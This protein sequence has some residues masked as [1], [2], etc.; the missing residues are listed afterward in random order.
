MH[1]LS[2]VTLWKLS[3]WRV[4]TLQSGFL[5]QCGHSL[6]VNR[7][8]GINKTTPFTCFI[9]YRSG[10]ATSSNILHCITAF[11]AIRFKPVFLAAV[12][13]SKIHVL[14]LS[15]LVI[16]HSGSSKYKLGN[17]PEPKVVHSWASC[18]CPGSRPALHAQDMTYC[19]TRWNFP[20][21]WISYQP[22][23]GQ[24]CHVIQKNYN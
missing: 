10:T 14:W 6:Q 1:D 5:H 23:A 18:R 12:I 19:K 13:K 24:Q 7:K 11:P 22:R 8:T 2:C 15:C 3:S 4:G 17:R 20:A 9:S 16:S 21:V